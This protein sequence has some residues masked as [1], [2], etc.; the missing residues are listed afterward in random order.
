MARN[1]AAMA[2][3]AKQ[4]PALPPP[5]GAEA[6]QLPPMAPPTVAGG[7]QHLRAHGSSGPRV[8]RAP[9]RGAVVLRHLQQLRRRAV[10]LRHLGGGGLLAFRRHV[11]APPSR[12]GRAV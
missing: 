11:T 4:L 6:N 9:C 10:A 1:H 5:P 12:P 2:T 3:G 8:L 7:G